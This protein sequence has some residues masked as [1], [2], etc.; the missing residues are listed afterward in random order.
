M[1]RHYARLLASA[2]IA[3]L[4]LATGGGSASAQSVGGTVT[5]LS[6]AYDSATGKVQVVGSAVGLAKDIVVVEIH[7]PSGALLYFGTA[8][9]DGNGDFAASV[10]V[11]TLGAGTYKVRS[12]D[13]TGGVY[14]VAA[15]TV[16]QADTS[17]PPPSEESGP[18][19]AQTPP[20]EVVTSSD[21]VTSVA[22]VTGTI[23][24][25]GR[26]TITVS[27][28]QIESAVA[29]ALEEA[30][31]SGA[32]S[33]GVE[34]R[35]ELGAG[36]QSS[37]TTIPKQSVDLIA[38][39]GVTT[40]TVST[41]VAS[42]SFGER[43]LDAISRSAGQDV[44]IHAALV[45]SE[46]ISDEA[47]QVVGQRPVYNFSVTSG[48][49]TIS[50]FGGPVTVSVPYTLQPG[51]DPDA[52]VIYFINAEGK[53]EMVENCIYDPATG[54]VTFRTDHF[55]T[56]VVGYNDVSFADV[57][58]GAWYSK[59]VRFIA[60]RNITTGTGDNHYTPM[61]PVTRGQFIVM[62]MRAY[63]VRPDDGP[64]DNFEDAGDTYYTGFLAAARRLGI[65]DGVGNNLFA[66]DKEIARQEMFAMLCRTLATVG[67]LPS[68]DSGRELSSF[69]DSSFLEPWAQEAAGVLVKG[70]IVQGDENRLN[71]TKTATR[72]EM[73]EMIHRL[74]A[75]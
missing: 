56:Y 44:V 24:G 34:I 19:P 25:S 49:T 31:K 53:P 57:P 7:T 66:P 68:K 22:N 42:I 10:T 38:G 37:E 43:A 55:S 40:M 3:V 64:K 39:S 18:P 54:T 26:A 8:P 63:G 6:A 46:T 1:N 69:E 48:N 30:G 29:M 51:E 41:P 33:V 59:A 28:T 4:C 60:A 70:G 67:N 58:E 2:L 62:I 20:P 35:G 15:F 50:E 13:Y 27:Q 5:E 11:G 17:S 23:D 73:A 61:G 32:S 16:P 71:P 47:R 74:F 14:E 45:G 52:V 21:L 72:A 9:A 12:A 36:A 75:R 65:S